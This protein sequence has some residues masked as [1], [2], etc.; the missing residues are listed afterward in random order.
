MAEQHERTDEQSEPF[1]VSVPYED[2]PLVLVR[3]QRQRRYRKLA[4]LVTLPALVLGS[5]TVAGAYQ[6]GI[7]GTEKETCVPDRVRAP[8]RGSFDLT[9][10]NATET[11]GQATTTGTLLTRRGFHL[12]QAGNARQEDYVKGVA[13]IYHGPEGLDQAL[14]VQKQM[15][16]AE[17]W[18]DGRSGTSVQ[19]LL[20]YGYRKLA[21]A[22]PPPLPMPDKVHLNVY[23]TTWIDGL[24]AKVGRQ[25]ESRG[26]RV[27]E[28]GPDPE[29]SFNPHDRVVIRYGAAGLEAAQRVEQHFAGATMKETDREDASVDVVIGSTY[30]GLRPSSQVPTPVPPPPVIDH[31]ERPCTPS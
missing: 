11:Q 13:T 6:A 19:V 16:G 25:L 9:I 29:N 15:P 1:Y 7:I 22:P 2:L 12:V 5:A 18:D 31:V 21:P 14:L 4:L 17:L 28:V 27:D 8:E 24:G 30:R 3:E 20:G 10:L 26:F 23:N